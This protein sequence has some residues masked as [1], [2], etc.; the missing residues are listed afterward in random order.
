MEDFFLKKVKRA[1]STSTVS[2]VEWNLIKQ[3]VL[4]TDNPSLEALDAVTRK[5][6]FFV[7]H[8]SLTTPAL[9]VLMLSA[10]SRVFG[11]EF[12]CLTEHGKND[13]S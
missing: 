7:R 11:R 9:K 6:G 1:K 8:S 12:Q 13:I 10:T 5:K 4:N 2:N 3:V